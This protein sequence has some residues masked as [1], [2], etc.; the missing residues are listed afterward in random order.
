M[1]KVEFTKLRARPATKLMSGRPV[2][3]QDSGNTY[4]TLKIMTLAQHMHYLYLTADMNMVT[5][6]TL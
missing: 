6:M 3:N 5:L 4:G 1:K 2:A